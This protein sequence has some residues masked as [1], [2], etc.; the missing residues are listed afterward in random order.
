MEMSSVLAVLS[1]V[2]YVLGLGDRHPSNLLLDRNSGKNF[3][4]DGDCF[5]VEMTKD[6]QDD[7]T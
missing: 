1:M 5:D 2:G 4:I 6:D 7:L 3:H